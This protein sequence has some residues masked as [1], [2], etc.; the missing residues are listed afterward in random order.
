MIST[1]AYEIGAVFL[2][3]ALLMLGTVSGFVPRILRT[4]A[5]PI[6]FGVALLGFVV[7]R[8]GPDLYAGWL[9]IGAVAPSLA[10]SRPALAGPVPAPEPTRS[11]APHAHAAKQP[12]AHWKTIIIDDSV[13]AATE[14]PPPPG[15]LI[16]DADAKPAVQSSALTEH[17]DTTPAAKSSA[18]TGDTGNAAA[19]SCCNSPYDSGIRRAVKSIGHFLHI[20][21]KKEQ[22]PQ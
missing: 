18:L 13:P 12:E 6:F 21:R 11:A 2:L 20:G 10:S 14:P 22:A 19:E 7:Y 1:F 5:A 8:F 16:E 9:S 17:A 15:R 4:G 3:A